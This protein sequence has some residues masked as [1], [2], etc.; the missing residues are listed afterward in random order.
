MIMGHVD[1]VCLLVCVRIH[2]AT[3][4][5]SLWVL[6]LPSLDQAGGG[7]FCCH[8]SLR[9]NGFLRR[10]LGDFVLLKRGCLNHSLGAYL[11]VGAS[12]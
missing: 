5:V 1:A 2:W 7:S 10:F 11:K 12:E 4:S 9:R 8:Y 6:D 3:V